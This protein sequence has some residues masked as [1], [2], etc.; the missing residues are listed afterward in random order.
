MARLR[1]LCPS[2]VVQSLSHVFVTPWT[3]ARQASLSF[4][5]SWSLLKRVS[6][7]SVMPSSHLIL[8]HPLGCLRPIILTQSPSWWHTR[9]SAKME[10]SDKDSGKWSVMWCLLLTFPELFQLVVAY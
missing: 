10:A 3:A 7:E 2:P 6:I 1:G 5:L 4:T 9:C 8:C